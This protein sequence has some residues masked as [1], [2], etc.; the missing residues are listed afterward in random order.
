MVSKLK[1][2]HISLSFIYPSQKAGWGGIPIHRSWWSKWSS[3]NVKSSSPPCLQATSACSNPDPAATPRPDWKTFRDLRT[4]RR[5]AETAKVGCED[6]RPVVVQRVWP[7]CTPPHPSARRTGGCRS[8]A[9][10]APSCSFASSL[11]QLLLRRRVQLHWQRGVR[12]SNCSCSKPRPQSCILRTWL[13][14]RILERWAWIQISR[15]D[16]T[17]R[18]KTR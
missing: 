11:L 18:N 7:G 15:Q 4:L 16:K 5:W 13:E 6:C 10:A 1:T 12:R 14:P 17:R 8:R 3:R 2:T 9:A